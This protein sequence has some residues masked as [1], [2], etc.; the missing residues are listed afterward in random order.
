MAYA[1][2]YADVVKADYAKL[3]AAVAAGEVAAT[4]GI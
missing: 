2:S 3:L 1:C 4:P